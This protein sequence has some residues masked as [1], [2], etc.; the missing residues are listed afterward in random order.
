[1]AF[2]SESSD[3]VVGDENSYSDVFVRDLVAGITVRAS[4][5]TEGGDPEAH[6]DRPSISG[7]GRYVAYSS[8]ASDLVFGDR[9]HYSDIFVRDLVAGTTVPSQREYP[10]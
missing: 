10:G 2:D 7:D 9:H 6:S 8:W 1:M 4:V 3:L 5:D